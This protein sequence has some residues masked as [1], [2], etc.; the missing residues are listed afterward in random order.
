ML[1]T[2]SMLFRIGY[3]LRGAVELL[4]MW[5]ALAL[6]LG[7]G[8]AIWEAG[9]RGT[10]RKSLIQHLRATEDPAEAEREEN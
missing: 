2:F 8:L 4:G 1:K 7:L 6:W 9:E 5:G 10:S 3:F